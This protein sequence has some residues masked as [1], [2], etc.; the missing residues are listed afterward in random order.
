MV[1]RK[2]YVRVKAVSR[3]DMGTLRNNLLANVRLGS[4]L[5]TDEYTSYSGLGEFYNHKSVN[6]VSGNYVSAGNIHTNTIESFWAGMK[7][8]IYGIYHSISRKH[9]DLYL[10]EFTYRY[11][12]RKETDETKFNLVLSNCN[13]R[14]RYAQLIQKQNEN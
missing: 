3:V 4:R 9:I 2:G 8:S 7:R 14:L 5:M 1:Q 10:N 12:T 11:N 13:G 6:H